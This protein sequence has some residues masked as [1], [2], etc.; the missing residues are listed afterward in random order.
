MTTQ[1][2]QKPLD[3][4]L[5]KPIAGLAFVLGW[6]IAIVA[7]SILHNFSDPGVRGFIADIGILT[8][9]VGF[10]APFVSSKRNFIVILGWSAIALG[11]FAIADFNQIHVIVYMLRLGIPLLALLTPLFKLLSFRVF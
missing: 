4:E 7:W 3:R 1:T 5:G 11:V 9:A 10:A 2:I 6:A 8:A